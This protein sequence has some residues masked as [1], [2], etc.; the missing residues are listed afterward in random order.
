MKSLAD[1]FNSN[2]SN[3]IDKWSNYF[4]VYERHLAR[5]RN[6]APVVLEI[7][8]FQG[9]GLRMWREYFGPGARIIGVDINPECKTLEG[10]QIEVFIGSQE[11]RSFLRSLKGKI[12]PVDIL[13]DDGGHYMRQ[14]IMTFD[15][16]FPLVKENGVYLCEDLHTSY[17]AEYG[18]GLRRA[19]TFIEYGKR[20]VDQLSA[21]HSREPA[22]FSVNGFTKQAHS[23]HFYDGMMVIEKKNMSQPTRVRSGKMV[24][25]PYTPPHFQGDAFAKLRQSLMNRLWQ[26]KQR[27]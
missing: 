23:I 16:L 9:G 22:G 1:I 25:P 26:I 15:E 11:D 3:L 5:F 14:Q 27:Q 17:W 24:L 12:P 10:D 6:Q 13:I 4:D 21:W 8:V 19:G 7:G 2:E 20:L 18:G